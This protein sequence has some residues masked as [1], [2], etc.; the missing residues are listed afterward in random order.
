MSVCEEE[1]GDEGFCNA[2]CAYDYNDANVLCECSQVQSNF[3]RKKNVQNTLVHCN[4]QKREIEREN[5]KILKILC[6]Y[7]LFCCTIGQ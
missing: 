1:C 2:K 6:I 7:T 5:E 3:E 4:K